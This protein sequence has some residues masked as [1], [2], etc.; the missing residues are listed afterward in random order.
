MK[1]VAIVVGLAALVASA[2]AVR[3]MRGDTTPA[4]E[5]GPRRLVCATE[6][7]EV[8]ADLADASLDVRVEP[9][10]DTAERLRG[11][12]T[13]G[14]DAWLAPRP[15]V[16]MVRHDA[17]AAGRPDPLGT[18]SE[19]LA[20]TPLVIIV[21]SD[22][23]AV[24][25]RACQGRIDWTCLASRGGASWELLGGS[26]SW[27]QVKIGLDDPARTTSG[28]L[29]LGQM[30]AT[31]SGHSPFDGRDLESV[32]SSLES[33]LGALPA[34]GDR[35][36]LDTMLERA[37]S[38]DLAVTLEAG[39]RIAIASPRASGQLELV[40]VEPTTSADA[41]LVSAAGR[42]APVDDERVRRSL[43]STG[44]HFP[45]KAGPGVPDAVAGNALVRVSQDARPAR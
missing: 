7:A 41:V 29:A 40:E 2:L 1:R 24:L 34:P 14:A 23:R 42:H 33:V 31:F 15:W 25:E 45:D 12:G 26:A 17:R 18:P 27:G 8:C 43:T 36:A 19:T 21:R 39:S 4:E 32:R 37:D 6:M 10:G 3:A 28:L 11:G 38:F 13:L 5:T 22:R 35:S 9:P 44:W 20:R 16:D 30:A